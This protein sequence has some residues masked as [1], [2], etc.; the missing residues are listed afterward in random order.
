MILECDVDVMM[1]ALHGRLAVGP[2]AMMVPGEVRA[3]CEYVDFGLHHVLVA[4]LE[5]AKKNN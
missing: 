4:V 5:I 3:V 1:R 2:Q